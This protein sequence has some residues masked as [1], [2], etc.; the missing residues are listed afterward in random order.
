MV[1]LVSDAQRQS[2]IIRGEADA[3]RNAI[4]AE[5]FGADKEFFEFYR[6]M[7]AY[8]K[9][10]KSEDTRLLISP[11]SEFFKYFS[12]PSGGSRPAPSSVQ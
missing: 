2:E 10:L 12:D 1:E 4:F 8:E 7:Q 9:G 3:K 5:A 11:D 6:S